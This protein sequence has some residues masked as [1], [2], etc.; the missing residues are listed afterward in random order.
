[1]DPTGQLRGVRTP[2][3]PGQLR[4]CVHS[5]IHESCM[6]NDAYFNLSSQHGP[7]ICWATIRSRVLYRTNVSVNFDHMTNW[8]ESPG[9]RSVSIPGYRVSGHILVTRFQCC[10][11]PGA[12][13]GGLA[14]A[15]LLRSEFFSIL[16]FN[17]KK[18][19]WY[20]KTFENEG[21]QLKCTPSPFHI[22]KYAAEINVVTVEFSFIHLPVC[23][24]CLYNTRM[25]SNVLSIQCYCFMMNNTNKWI[26]DLL[27][28]L[29]F[30][31]PITET[32]T[33][34][35]ESTPPARNFLTFL[36][37]RLGIFNPNFT[38]LLHVPIYAGIQSFIQL[39]ATL[40]KLCH[41]KRDHHNVLKMSTIS[42]N[43]LGVVA[44]NMA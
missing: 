7:Y 16:I 17:V 5:Y 40:T 27:Y 14:H 29:F 20:L 12:Y 4:R 41:I 21:L 44:L 37:K 3:P 35:W 33:I 6:L 19:C 8:A 36:P 25:S 24:F 10:Y 32:V 38:R 28:S 1:M 43:A 23:Q 18:L 26:E 11:L 13:F 42:R 39:S 34:Q 15:P 31:I 9:S 22:S 2:G 30:I